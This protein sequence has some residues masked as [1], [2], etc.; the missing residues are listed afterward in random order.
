MGR[1]LAIDYGTKRCGIAVTDP[2]KII[3]TPLTYI[4]TVE[5]FTFLKTYSLKETVELFL[6]GMPISL[7]GNTTN[8]THFVKIFIEKLK[9]AFPETAIETIDER[10][11]SK[12]ALKT[13]IEAGTTKKFRKEKGNI[14]QISATIF[15]Q[16]WMI[17]N[18]T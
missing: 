8:A 14:D 11:T 2:L 5:I 13:L 1:V 4:D 17:R 18:I 16:D 6:V 7:K 10:F 9:Q 3:A 15:L 12:M